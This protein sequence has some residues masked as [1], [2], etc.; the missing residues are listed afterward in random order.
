MKL[1]EVLERLWMQFCGKAGIGTDR[2]PVPTA[3]MSCP[4]GVVATQTW[5]EVAPVPAIQVS[6]TALPCGVDT[7]RPGDDCRLPKV[8]AAWVALSCT[9]GDDR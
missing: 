5:H 3:A 1:F 7:L 8:A 2:L 9:A 4:P 6:A